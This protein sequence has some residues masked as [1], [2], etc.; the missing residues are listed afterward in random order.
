MRA[1]RKGFAALPGIPQSPCT[2]PVRGGTEEEQ[3]LRK[4][5]R[6][7]LRLGAEVSPAPKVQLLGTMAAPAPRDAKRAR[8]AALEARVSTI[9]LPGL[10][11]IWSVLA[12]KGGA[13]FLGTKSALF[14]HA[15]GRLTLL[16]GHPSE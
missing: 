14:L 10:G 15:D 16:A 6:C 12:V 13:R 9:E 11:L 8:P 5:C 1:A 2:E 7:R 3:R 4:L